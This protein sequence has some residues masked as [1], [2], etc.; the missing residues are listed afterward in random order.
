MYTTSKNIIQEENSLYFPITENV[1]KN[2]DV[3][4]KN[5]DSNT[6]KWNL[7][8][9]KIDL[10]AEIVEGVESKILNKN[11]G[12]FESSG[13]IDKNICLAAHNR[14][15]E[16]NYFEKINQLIKGDKIIYFYNNKKYEFEVVDN[17][18]I[19]D[20]NFE[21][22]ENTGKDE[23]TLITCVPNKESLRRCVKAIKIEE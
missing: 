22:L 17:F 6:K 9:P 3:I 23:M 4:E 12:H 5:E 21:V 2:I 14:G 19:E 13:I 7:E 20:T 15:Y 11:I 10:K 1:Q 8:I 16:K 18:I